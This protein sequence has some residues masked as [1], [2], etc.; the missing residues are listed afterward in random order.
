MHL[1]KR[2]S[3]IHNDM[4]VLIVEDDR[5]TRQVMNHLIAVR[6]HHITACA[7]AEDAETALEKNNFEV[8]ILDWMLPGKTGPDFCRWL[9]ARPGGDDIY[10]LLITARAT[11]ADLDE[12]LDAGANDYLVKPWEIEIFRSRL[13]IAERQVVDIAERRKS[14][15]ALND[16][17]QRLERLALVARQTQNGVV[18][19]NAKG[20]VEWANAAFGNMIRLNSKSI[21]ANDFTQML[22][23]VESSQRLE[24]EE[25]IAMGRA[26]E[27]EL[28][29]L[30]NDGAKHW[31]HYSLTPLEPEKG[32]LRGLVCLFSDITMVKKADEERFKTSKIESLGV[33]AGGIAHDLNNILTVISGNISLARLCMDGKHDKVVEHLNTADKAAFRA[34]DLSKQLLTFAKGGDPLKQVIDIKELVEKA[35]KFALYGSNLTCL[36]AL[37]KLQK[38]QADPYQIEQAVN[39]IVINAREAMPHG[40]KLQVCGQ[41]ETLLES[42]PHDLAPGEYIRISFA[43]DGPGITPDVLPQIFD[44]YF[45]TKPT[46]SGLGLTI[47]FSIITKHGGRILVEPVPGGGTLFNVFLPVAHIS[48]GEP[49]TELETIDGQR[50]V[51]CMDDEPTIRDL[52]SAMLTMS[53]YHV[54][55][56][57]DGTEAVAAYVDQMNKG[58]KFDVVILDATIPGGMGGVDTIKA[59]IHIDPEVRAII[60]SGYSD[61]SAL[62]AM[63]SFGFKASLPKPFTSKQLEA[64]IDKVIRQAA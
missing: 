2:P 17:N 9:R 59:L 31:L 16:S 1:G 32:V 49:T 48:T 14:R 60:C 40:G 8:V 13:R 21:V 44:P 58:K 23:G 56:T 38:V 12:A 11:P 55:T 43:D 39:N 46:G 51:L 27:G 54:V 30:G 29:I 47:A 25:A 42:N 3:A 37:P 20:E 50:T 53:G 24:M 7:N 64:M 45:T 15:I 63:E 36:F 10:V 26:S 4:N 52:T 41:N 28:A 6:G 33:L 19:L 22:A 5:T 61:E 34:A 57:C 35:T 62:A 18:I